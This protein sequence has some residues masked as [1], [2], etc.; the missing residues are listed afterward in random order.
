MYAIRSYY[1]VPRDNRATNFGLY[2]AD[3]ATGATR[4]LMGGAVLHGS[5]ITSYNVCYT[6]LLRAGIVGGW[7][8]G[9]G[10]FGNVD[11]KRL[12]TAKDVGKVVFD[13]SFTLVG[14]V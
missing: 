5:R 4:L 1:G 7:Y 2:A 8:D 14:Y 6:K 9:D 13:K 10:L 11:G 12:T 3:P